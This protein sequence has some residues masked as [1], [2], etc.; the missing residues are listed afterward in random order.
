LTSK[1]Y[2]GTNKGV[3]QSVVEEVSGTA[4]KC[5]LL[6]SIHN[7]ASTISTN[8]AS[9][10]VSQVSGDDP[11]IPPNVPLYCVVAIAY[12]R[13]VLNSSNYAHIDSSSSSVSS[14]S[15]SSSSSSP[16]SSLPPPTSQS[17]YVEGTERARS[18]LSKFGFQNKIFD[19]VIQFLDHVQ[20][21][22]Q[23]RKILEKD[24]KKN[25][26]K[27]GYDILEPVWSELI[28]S[29]AAF[30]SN[31]SESIHLA[32]EFSFF[33][34]Q[35]Q[36]Q[37][38]QRQQRHQ[39]DTNEEVDVEQRKRKTRYTENDSQQAVLKKTKA[40][41]K[42]TSR[43]KRKTDGL[44]VPTIMPTIQESVDEVCEPSSS[45]LET[46]G[47]DHHHHHHPIPHKIIVVTEV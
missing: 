39:V 28:S 27:L 20:S 18:L 15:S 37:Q 1:E 6:Y 16:S 43:K 10:Q 35:Q 7:M 36:Q 13:C 41:T 21:S 17:W 4:A 45:G 2:H 11:L 38:Q 44:S 5:S 26:A 33:T 19:Q 30:G 22:H 23:T 31:I 34:S 46:G 47:V 25:N 9:P 3:H 29:Q 8:Q 42:S 40:K 12:L 14:S 32:S 24:L